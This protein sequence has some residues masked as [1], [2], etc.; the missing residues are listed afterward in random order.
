[1]TVSS[2]W[3]L[4]R[5]LFQEQRDILPGIL[6]EHNQLEFELKVLLLVETTLLAT[7]FES[8]DTTWGNHVHLVI[9]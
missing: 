2:C 7:E 6:Q 9:Q 8:L 5:P 4:Y 1:M 3:I